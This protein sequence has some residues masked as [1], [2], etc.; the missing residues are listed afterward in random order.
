M[1]ALV[2]L[3]GLLACGCAGGEG[4]RWSSAQAKHVT[5]EGV[6]YQ[7]QYVRDA[8]GVDMR[9]VR[10][11]LVVVMPDAMVERR[12]NTAAAMMVARDLCAGAVVESEQKEGDQYLTRARCG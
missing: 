6:P 1:R 2:I 9:S 5:V 11:E 4:M 8:G 12:R 3:T 10:T 7:V